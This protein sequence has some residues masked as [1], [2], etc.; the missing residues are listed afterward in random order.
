MVKFLEKDGKLVCQFSDHMDSA[1]CMDCEYLVYEKILQA[2]L[3]TAFDMSKVE[4]ISSDF[5][6]ICLR[7]SKDMGSN[8]FELINVSEKIRKVFEVSGLDKC[9]DIK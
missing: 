7:A 3:P 8:G 9:V 6:R 5:L 2:N 4:Y 1:N